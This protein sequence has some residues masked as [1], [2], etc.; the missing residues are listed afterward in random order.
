[1]EAYNQGGQSTKFEID[2]SGSYKNEVDNLPGLIR[3]Y[4]YFAGDS[5]TYR[6]AFYYSTNR[7]SPSAGDTYS[8]TNSDLF[9]RQFAATLYV[10]NVLN[11]LVMRKVDDQQQAVNGVTMALYKK[12]QV[13]VDGN[14]VTLDSNASLSDTAV[15]GTVQLD[16]S[17]LDGACVFDHLTPGTYYVGEY[18]TVP[19]YSLNTALSKVIVDGRGVHADAGTSDDG[20]TVSVGVGRIVRSVVQ[21][22]AADDIDQTLH[23]IVATPQLGD[24]S[25]ESVTFTDA[26]GATKIHLNY[27]MNSAALDYALTDVKDNAEHQYYTVDAGMPALRINQ[28]LDHNDDTSDDTS[29]SLVTDLGDT[30]LTGLFSGVT[31][32]Q[33]ADQRVGSLKIAK[34]VQS[35]DSVN[36]PDGWQNQEFVF[37]VTATDRGGEPLDGSYKATSS[38]GSVTMVEF[39]MGTAEVTLKHGQ[40]IIIEELPVGGDA[41]FTVT[42][43]ASG[44]YA[45]EYTINGTG[46]VSNGVV[47]GSLAQDAANC[48][49]RICAV[50]DPRWAPG[51]DVRVTNTYSATAQAAFNVEKVLEGLDWDGRSF[52]FTVTPS[53]DTSDAI[54]EGY[55]KFEGNDITMTGDKVSMVIDSSDSQNDYMKQ[56]SLEAKPGTYV[57]T[58]T[59]DPGDIDG[60]VYDDTEYTVTVKVDSNLNVTYSVAESA[61]GQLDVGSA[62]DVPVLTFTNRFVKVSALPLTGG[63]ATARNWMLAGG[64]L[65]LLPA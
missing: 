48:D 44:G 54:D 17:K 46:T 30:D 24:A 7:D 16:N 36:L 52:T 13:H 38:D 31:V 41:A 2:K 26:E 12:D 55:V 14:T 29:T 65:L 60:L 18:E 45:P 8:V 59:E 39:N 25:G 28:C 9:T 3:N 37:D 63:N 64:G 57:F 19:G 1:M 61:G 15:T 43:Q 23:N 11:R 49:G 32:V 51:V 35:D 47:S 21:F 33:I 56:V 53:H 42:E 6:T 20:V 50:T 5:G 22:A 34:T 58:V 40:S 62:T 4:R 10:P 27:D